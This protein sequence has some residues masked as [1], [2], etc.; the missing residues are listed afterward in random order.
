MST[1]TTATST[2]FFSLRAAENQYNLVVEA[3]KSQAMGDDP[4]GDVRQL[5][6]RHILMGTDI[7]DMEGEQV[8]STA[9]IG[10]QKHAIAG[11]ADVGAFFNGEAE[12][13]VQRHRTIISHIKE[14]I[15]GRP[16]AKH[17]VA[18]KTNILHLIDHTNLP[19]TNS[20]NLI[21]IR[22]G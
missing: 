1:S 16:I 2:C 18:E 7:E 14:D 22:G 19:I 4:W 15:L 3:I 12:G 20:A 9:V 6:K 10:E 5:G 17:I 8:V 21:S 13:S 11:S